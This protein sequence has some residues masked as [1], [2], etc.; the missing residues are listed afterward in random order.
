MYHVFV[1]HSSLSG[2]VSD[3]H[4]LT[5]EKKSINECGRTYLFEEIVSFGYE[6][7]SGTI[8]SH[9]SSIF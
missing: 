5:N 2:H 3:L 9:D 7:R 4:T 6:P 8:V 1:K